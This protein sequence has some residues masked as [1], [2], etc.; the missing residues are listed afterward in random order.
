MRHCAGHHHKKRV[1]CICF[2]L[3]NEGHFDIVVKA[4][5]S[6][7]SSRKEILRSL[8]FHIYWHT[9]ALY[10]HTF[11]DDAIYRLEHST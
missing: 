7:A 10:S 4:Y 2:V 9:S 11:V 3:F 6:V 8:R 5:C 1:C